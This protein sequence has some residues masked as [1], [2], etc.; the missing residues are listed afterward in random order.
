[1]RVRPSNDS[2]ARV[3]AFATSNTSIKL[4]TKVIGTSQAAVASR[5]DDVPKSFSFDYVASPHVSQETFFEKVGRPMAEYCLTGYNGCIFAY[6]Q[7]GSGKTYTIQGPDGPHR[8]EDKGLTV[9]ILEYIFRKLSRAQRASPNY[10]YICECSY[11][12]LYQEQLRD[13]LADESKKLELREDL[14][15]GVYVDNM[16][17][18]P[19]RSA[20]D[21]EGLFLCGAKKRHV[22]ASKANDQSSRSHAIFTI[23]IQIQELNEEGMTAIKSSMLH[24]VDLA[25]SERQ[26]NTEASGTRLQEA[27]TINKSLTHLG[28][29]IRALIDKTE[30]KNVHVPYRESKLTFLL[31]QSLGGNSKTSI[32]ATV[33]PGLKS[34][35]E[36]LSTLRFADR[37]KMIRNNAVINESSAGTLNQLQSE[38]KRL[39]SEIHSLRAQNAASAASSSSGPISPRNLSADAAAPATPLEIER[40]ERICELEELFRT[41]VERLQKANVERDNF[42]LKVMD[43]KKLLLAQESYAESYKL[44]T[45]LREDKIARLQKCSTVEE[46]RE[47]DLSDEEISRLKAEIDALRYQRDHHPD[48]LRVT[49]ENLELK[50]VLEQYEDH[51]GPDGEI[52]QLRAMCSKFSSQIVK[53]STD[54]AK[55]ISLLRGDDE[56]AELEGEIGAEGLPASNHRLDAWSHEVKVERLEAEIQRIKM[57]AMQQLSAGD[58][59]EANLKLELES[60]KQQVMSMEDRMTKLIETHDEEKAQLEKH[61]INLSETVRDKYEREVKALYDRLEHAHVSSVTVLTMEKQLSE[62]TDEYVLM[63]K[64]HFDM[65]NDLKALYRIIESSYNKSDLDSDSY[66]W[67]NMSPRR[68]PQHETPLKGSSP[69]P[70]DDL[71]SST[72]ATPKKSV[73]AVPSKTPSKSPWTPSRAAMLTPTSRSGL[74]PGRAVMSVPRLAIAKIQELHAVVAD[75]TSKISELENSLAEIDGAHFAICKDYEDRIGAAEDKIAELESQ[76]SDVQAREAS[77]REEL[78]ILGSQLDCN[79]S[80]LEEK[81][82]EA[83]HLKAQL[84]QL[85]SEATRLASEKDALSAQS[86]ALLS[87]IRQQKDEQVLAVMKRQDEIESE[88]LDTKAHLES[89]I[90]RAEDLEARLEATEEHAA[91]AN[92]TLENTRALVDS[93]TLNCSDKDERIKR[94]KKELAD[95]NADRESLLTRLEVLEA[96][97]ESLQSLQRENEELICAA[98]ESCRSL[99]EAQNQLSCMEE[100]R[101]KEVL[102]LEQE[103]EVAARA[104]EQLQEENDEIAGQLHTAKAQA[105]KLT[106]DLT[107]SQSDAAQLKTTLA[108]DQTL[109]SESKSHAERLE[110]LLRAEHVKSAKLELELAA[111]SNEK[112]NVEDELAKVTER[113]IATRTEL[114]ECIA[115]LQEKAQQLHTIV[116][117]GTV[118]EHLLREERDTLL[119][120]LKQSQMDVQHANDRAN[121]ASEALFTLQE[122]SAD[123]EAELEKKIQERD[124]K[125]QSMQHNNEVSR[126]QYQEADGKNIHEIGQLKRQLRDLAQ[127]HDREIADLRSQLAELAVDKVVVAKDAEISSLKTQVS[128]ARSEISSLREELEGALAEAENQ[129]SALTNAKIE[130]ADLSSQKNGKIKYVHKMKM[131]NIELQK[132]VS[133]LTAKVAELTSTKSSG[134]DSL[135]SSSGIVHGLTT[136]TGLSR[137]PSGG[138]SSST[139]ISPSTSSTVLSAAAAPTTK[140][141][142]LRTAPTATASSLSR[143]LRPP[144][145]PELADVTNAKPASIKRVAAASEE[146]KPAAPTAPTA[147]R[148]VTTRRMTTRTSSDHL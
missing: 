35:G 116:N 119:L 95:A 91:N 6:G 23:Y 46:A 18:I 70:Y 51:Y 40:D 141:S 131:E 50:E 12:E 15:K 98:K 32:I 25:G 81:E 29:T 2:Q 136:S 75:Y 76:V 142:I 90:Q 33:D 122:Q 120:Q 106:A 147:A 105:K 88:L 140:P 44:I 135:A 16:A 84:K 13:L 111:L 60:S 118:E 109:L 72:A 20:E 87:Q 65:Q 3:C 21:G 103:R 10:H 133:D 71:N 101:T 9:R 7:T 110:G 17:K 144:S 117:E 143:N 36:T 104:F 56:A 79:S 121:D 124:A 30:K 41:M 22:A 67:E 43:L 148:G 14:K 85:E 28:K 138:L 130:F 125:L 59:R 107:A 26:K 11:L 77:V 92:A 80:M 48:V 68:A 145:Q 123:R 112:R 34:Y 100:S 37:A 132:Q 19:I 58:E 38:I 42:S 64:V 114:D 126:R 66:D 57:E 45:R 128:S 83:S 54:K 113:Q 127:T 108:R 99:R 96:A 53:L 134:P 5:G 129:S 63:K 82:G 4:D 24:I 139:G 1:M 78:E 39:Q 102:E 8:A 86:S 55:L 69:L 27:G 146:L 52:Q 62:Q 97:E 115:T 74:T 61:Y 47:I 89:E 31:K 49:I 94:F 137:A 93:L 73:L